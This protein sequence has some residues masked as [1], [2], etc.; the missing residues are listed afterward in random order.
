M[1]SPNRSPGGNGQHSRTGPQAR[2]THRSDVSPREHDAAQ[3]SSAPRTHEQRGTS[4]RRAS[5]R[6]S[7]TPALHVE[8]EGEAELQA[9]RNANGPSE[10]DETQRREMIATSAYLRAEQRGFDGGSEL[11]D[12][13]AAEDEV[14]AWLR[15]IDRGAE[16]PPLFEE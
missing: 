14:D 8:R 7:H 16:E 10:I 15:Q 5:D 1:S 9:L 4:V 12:W 6:T 11:A 2:G 13:L 3:G